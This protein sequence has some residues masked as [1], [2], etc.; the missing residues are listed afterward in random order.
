MIAVD[1][2]FLCVVMSFR[3][4][5]RDMFMKLPEANEPKERMWRVI[6]DAIPLPAFIVDEDIR[7]LDFNPA[8]EDLLGPS[9]KS[10]LRRRGGEVFNCVHSTKAGCGK[11]KACQK[12]VIRNSVKDAV[13]GLNTRRKFCQPELR[14]S[15]AVVPVSFFV[16]ASRLPETEP[17]LALL[18]L[19]NVA[20]TVRLYKRN[21]AA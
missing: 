1:P 7:I 15:R 17:P 5:Q 14:D 20:E 2:F 18:I 8:A 13:N 11:S 4:W 19:E 16:T 10:S 21:V 6:F 9:P 3:W 12:C